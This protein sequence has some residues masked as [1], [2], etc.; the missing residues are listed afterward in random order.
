MNATARS[1]Q[2]KFDQADAAHIKRDR[3][4]D[5]RPESESIDADNQAA[6]IDDPGRNEPE[7]M[8]GVHLSRVA[9]AVEIDENDRDTRD[10]GKCADE[11]GEKTPSLGSDVG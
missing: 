6:D 5:G 2:C 3:P 9:A 10:S 11:R 1:P 7:K 4:G 8:F